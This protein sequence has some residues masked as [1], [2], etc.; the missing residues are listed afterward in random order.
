MFTLKLI[1][2]INFQNARQLNN[3]LADRFFSFSFPLLRYL[4]IYL[5]YSEWVGGLRQWWKKMLKR[6]ATR[7][8]K[9]VSN[10][11]GFTVR[12]FV[13]LLLDSVFSVFWPH[14]PSS[15]SRKPS[16]HLPCSYYPP[17]ALRS[18]TFS[19]KQQKQHFHFSSSLRSL[20]W[21]NM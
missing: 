15:Y 8:T 13:Y 5:F 4:A 14:S 1:N 12:P 9:K 19:S 11:R 2:N 3:S 21:E 6:R 20:S 16:N 10:I 17:M 18:S 7:N